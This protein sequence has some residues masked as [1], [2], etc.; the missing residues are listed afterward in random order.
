M[1]ACELLFP[2]EQED[3]QGKTQHEQ[4]LQILQETHS[5]QGDQVSG[6]AA[7]APSSP[8]YG[9]KGHHHR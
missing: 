6:L 2:Q 4:V 9:E 3:S 5:A 7:L 1:Q 8:I